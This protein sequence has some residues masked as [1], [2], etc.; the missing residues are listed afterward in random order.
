M[1][2]TER[3]KEYQSNKDSLITELVSYGKTEQEKFELEMLVTNL[4]L[5]E[6]LIIS[7]QNLLV[8]ESQ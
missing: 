7:N 5:T 1:T 8:L 2:T 3:I 6:D 4:I